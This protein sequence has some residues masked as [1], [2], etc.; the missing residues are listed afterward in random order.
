MLLRSKVYSDKN[1]YVIVDA[2]VVSDAIEQSRIKEPYKI[3]KVRQ[4]VGSILKP[5]ALSSAEE[6]TPKA[7]AEAE[8][9][10]AEAPSDAT[11]ETINIPSNETTAETS[12]AP[13]ATPDEAIQPPAEETAA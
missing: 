12:D 4:S 9:P 6:N 3:E 1:S 10:P 8:S 7:E 5:F 2:N 13:K 11:E